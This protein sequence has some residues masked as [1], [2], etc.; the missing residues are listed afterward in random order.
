VREVRV[1]TA[2]DATDEVVDQPALRR[3]IHDLPYR[4]IVFAF[5]T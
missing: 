2:I 4:V 1:Q 5:L 3:N